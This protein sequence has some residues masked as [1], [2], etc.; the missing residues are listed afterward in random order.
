MPDAA[1]ILDAAATAILNHAGAAAVYTPTCGAAV[2]LRVEKSVEMDE[3][4]DGLT[5][6][7]WSRIETVTGLLADFGQEPDR[8]DMI[9]IGATTYSVFRVLENDGRWI[10]VGVK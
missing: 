4:P 2:A 8:G 9:T 10:K 5:G 3:Q 1:S 6:A 7:T